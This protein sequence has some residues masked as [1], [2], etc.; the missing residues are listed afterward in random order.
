MIVPGSIEKPLEQAAGHLQNSQSVLGPAVDGGVYLIGLT[1]ENFA[2]LD[3]SAIS[4]Q[5]EDVFEELKLQLG[6]VQVLS[7]KNDIDHSRDLDQ[8]LK[9]RSIPQ[10]LRYQLQKALHAASTP[11]SRNTQTQVTHRIYSTHSLRGPP[12]FPPTFS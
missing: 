9:L 12:P 10:R 6:K 1:R 11:F 4:W 2:E 8:L 7:P 5:T 3:F